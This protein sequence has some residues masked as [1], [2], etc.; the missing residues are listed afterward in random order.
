MPYTFQCK[1][2]QLGSCFRKKHSEGTDGLSFY[3]RIAIQLILIHYSGTLL[4]QIVPRS[5]RERSATLSTVCCVS[6]FSGIRACAAAIFLL[7][8]HWSRSSTSRTASGPSRPAAWASRRACWI[9]LIT[10]ELSWPHLPSTAPSE[11]LGHHPPRKLGSAMPEPL[12]LRLRSTKC[13]GNPNKLKHQH[14]YVQNW[15]LM[16]RDK[17]QKTGLCMHTT[18]LRQGTTQSALPTHLTCAHGTLPKTI[19]SRL[20]GLTPVS[21][22]VFLDPSQDRTHKPCYCLFVCKVY[23]QPME[24]EAWE[25]VQSSPPGSWPRP[26]TPRPPRGGGRSGWLTRPQGPQKAAGLIMN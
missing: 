2:G 4:G 11:L 18:R 12:L 22:V 7:N 1:W 21:M 23:S 15:L 13:S 10:L 5:P 20:R 9:S 8:S 16:N 14:K 6:E 24:E 25:G 26:L 17:R 3:L 19:Y